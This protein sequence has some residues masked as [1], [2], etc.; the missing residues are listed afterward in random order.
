M[1]TLLL[2]PPPPPPLLLLPLLGSQLYAFFW[3]AYRL[4]FL[5]C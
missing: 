4:K 2:L 1:R 3:A 5:I